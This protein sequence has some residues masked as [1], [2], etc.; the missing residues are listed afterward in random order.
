M[1]GGN[2]VPETVA[3]KALEGMAV[4][5]SQADTQLLADWIARFFLKN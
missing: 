3:E 5:G 4:E 2:I 1:Y